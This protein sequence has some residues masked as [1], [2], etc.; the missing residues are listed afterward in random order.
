MESFSHIPCVDSPPAGPATPRNVFA[1]P[2]ALVTTTTTTWRNVREPHDS[3]RAST[4]PKA[5]GQPQQPQQQ[6]QL[7]QQPQPQYQYHDATQD[8]VP[9]HSQPSSSSA[10]P[11]S[12]R[13][14]DQHA[15]LVS[16]LRRENA[17]LHERL[18]KF[19]SQDMSSRAA[20]DLEDLPTGVLAAR[21]RQLELALQL[22]CIAREET[23]LK[24]EAQRSVISKL[25]EQV[26]SLSRAAQRR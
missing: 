20:E 7:P 12:G 3:G 1:P 16:E 8:M 9:S 14:L 13:D 15:R 2:P 6:Q 10:M 4:S 22:E 26:M 24:C 23:E 18:A 25:T 21:V 5:A 19:L 17:L 11:F